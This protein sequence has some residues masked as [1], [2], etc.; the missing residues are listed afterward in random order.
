[1]LNNILN[2]CIVYMHETSCSRIPCV[3]V[4]MTMMQVVLAMGNDKNIVICKLYLLL[5][6]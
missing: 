4:Y 3:L 1:M 5:R 2:K 6:W